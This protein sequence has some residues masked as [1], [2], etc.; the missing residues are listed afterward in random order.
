VPPPPPTLDIKLLPLQFPAECLFDRVY[1]QGAEENTWTQ[2]RGTDG[3]I[4]KMTLRNSIIYA[5]Y[6]ILAA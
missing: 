5:V 2:E 3:R 4:Y 1:E 6:K